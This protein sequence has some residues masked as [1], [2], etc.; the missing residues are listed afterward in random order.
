[1]MMVVTMTTMRAEKK[2]R[3]VGPAAWEA[4]LGGDGQKGGQG[5]QRSVR[6]RERRNRGRTTSLQ[7]R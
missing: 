3:S 1:M 4:P 6:E 5:G 2:A 7:G